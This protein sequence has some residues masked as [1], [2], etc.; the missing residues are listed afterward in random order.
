MKS[1]EFLT[2]YI[3]GIYEKQGN[4]NKISSTP[5]Y[6][7]LYRRINANKKQGEPK[8]SVVDY[9]YKIIGFPATEHVSPDMVHTL[10]AHCLKYKTIDNL[11][12]VDSYVYKK[13]K[14]LVAEC[15][16]ENL[17]EMDLLKELNLDSYKGK[18]VGVSSRYNN[19]K[20]ADAL[21]PLYAQIIQQDQNMASNLKSYFTKY[22]I[23][24]FKN[25][26]VVAP[27]MASKLLRMLPPYGGVNENMKADIVMY[28]GKWYT[29]E[30][31]TESTETLIANILHMCFRV[32]P[33]GPLNA[34]EKYLL[35]MYYLTYGNFR[36]M[37]RRN[38]ALYKNLLYIALELDIS[39]KELLET[40]GYAYNALTYSSVDYTAKGQF[41]EA[42]IANIP[43]YET[44]TMDRKMYAFLYD[45]ESLTDITIDNIKVGAQSD[46]AIYRA[47]AYGKQS[48]LKG[49]LV[50]SIYHSAQY[51]NFKDGNLLNIS[52]ANTEPA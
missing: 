33:H 39:I 28:K 43:S 49:K 4:F 18:P 17:T 21:F 44:I 37:Y 42:R 10:V 48:P 6:S 27:D 22:M 36:Y 29:K 25:M 13:Y 7:T 38:I 52:A 50:A 26:K 3:I 15:E 19:T 46:N 41:I 24:D 5:V 11:K 40:Q 31:Y 12:E 9:V 51:I 1:T 30:P 23:F 47:V 2:D 14:M 20:V 35:D 34:S 8:E 32:K 16:K 45:S